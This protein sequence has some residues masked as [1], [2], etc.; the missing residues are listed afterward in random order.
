MKHTEVTLSKH[1][2]VRT[3][4][5]PKTVICICGKKIRL[6]RNYDPNLLDRHI[7]NKIC[8]SND[9][10]SQIT[11]FFSTQNL[12]VSK[13]RKLC[14]GLSD[15][16]VKLYLR[17]VGFVT[18][19]GGAPPPEIVARE[20]FGNKIKSSFH[21][22]DL[23][24]KENDQLLDTLRSQA[25]W[26]NDSTT[27]C[28]RSTKCLTY[29]DGI[30]EVCRQCLDLKK[31]KVFLNAIDKPIPKEKNRKYTPL[32]L[33]KNFPFYQYCKN[34]NV[35][36]LL[37]VQ[38]AQSDLAIDDP[39]IC[40]ENMAKFRKFLNSIN[41]DS[42]IHSLGAILGS[43]LPLQETLISSYNEIDTIIKRIQTNNAIAK[44]VRI[45]I[46][47]VP[48]PK[49]PPF[50]LGIIPNNSENISNVYEIHNQVLEL[51]A[52]FKIHIL[53]IGADSASIEIKAQKNI[54]QINTETK[55]E[56]ND[57]LYGT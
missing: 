4:I 36:E 14:S 15:E 3:I 43:T 42:P 46:L 56:F 2:K 53:S 12:E 6:D 22:K 41:Y 20:L 49:V 26:I 34:A 40:F 9:G 38:H 31:S 39:S 55:L 30:N 11:Q 17:R 18:T 51:A 45:Y 37:G 19:F 1:L 54:M 44:Y 29:I 28:V 7:K 23:N 52:H 21:W 10:N 50:V 32:I 25:K 27:F 24:K 8:K 48:V 33:Y 5:D 13:K 57:K 47:Q 35:I 16:K